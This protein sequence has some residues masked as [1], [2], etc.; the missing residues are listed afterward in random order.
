MFK[1]EDQTRNDTTKKLGQKSTNRRKMP[2]LQPKTRSQRKLQQSR[3]TPAQ[4]R[5][6]R[7]Q[8]PHPNRMDQIK[9]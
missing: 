1:I 2:R 3:K 4:I 6:C 7:G 8:R 9:K 5:I